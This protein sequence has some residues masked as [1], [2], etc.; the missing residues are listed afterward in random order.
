MTVYK[1]SL[2]SIGFPCKVFSALLACAVLLSACRPTEAPPPT[3]R[4]ILDRSARAMQALQSTHFILDRTGAPAYVDP[5]NT[6]IF[7][8][9]EGDVKTP[10]QAQA[11]VRV[12]AP[13][14]VAEVSLVILGEDWYQTNPLT[15][16]WGRYAAQGYNPALFFD[17]DKGLGAV[18]RSSLTNLSLAGTEELDDFPGVR[19]YHLTAESPGEPVSAMT[20]GMMGRGRVV[21]D[22]WVRPDDY[23]VAR[24]R[25]VEPE[26]DAEAPTVWVMDLDK[27]DAPITIEAPIR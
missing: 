19:L 23:Y 20:A 13:G 25:A 7:K 24:V 17:P 3:A 10:D 16:E 21:F 1:L 9:A 11:K 18:M 27:Y 2:S 26:T 22:L 4:E 8:R 12:I 15:Q 6:F 14:F 5:T